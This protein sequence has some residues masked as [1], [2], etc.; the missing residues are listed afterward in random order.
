[1]AAPAIPSSNATRRS[2]GT[3]RL[4]EKLREL[5]ADEDAAYGAPAAS[6]RSVLPGTNPPQRAAKAR[7]A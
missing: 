3:M 2:S 4:A 7:A 6:P 5:R 1:M